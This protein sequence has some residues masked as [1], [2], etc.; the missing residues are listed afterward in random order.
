[1]E[2][3]T[4]LRSKSEMRGSQGE[5]GEERIDVRHYGMKRNHCRADESEIL[6]QAGGSAGSFNFKAGDAKG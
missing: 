3:K 1:M 6:I 4:S 5:G 2:K